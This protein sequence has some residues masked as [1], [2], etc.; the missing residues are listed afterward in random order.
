MSQDKCK[1]PGDGLG[2]HGNDKCRDFALCHDDSVKRAEQNAGGDSYRISDK[3]RK[4]VSCHTA[5]YHDSRRH[6]GQ[7]EHRADRQV[8]AVHDNQHTYADGG[9]ADTGNLL[10]YINHIAGA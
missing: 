1:A 3:S 9:D 7:R 6:A 4:S 5:R 10:Q 2:A 8:D